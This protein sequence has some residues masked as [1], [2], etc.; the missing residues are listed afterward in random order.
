MH[1]YH[2]ISNLFTR[3][4]ETGDIIEGS[5]TKDEFSHLQNLTWLWTEKFDGTNIRVIFDNDGVAE[6]RGKTDRAQIPPLLLSHLHDKFDEIEEFAG[7]TLYGEGIGYKIQ[8]GGLYVNGE[9]RC[10]FV[11]F[12]VRAGDFWLKR[13]DV[14]GIASAFSI[15]IVPIVSYGTLCQAMDFVRAG[16]KSERNNVLEAEGLICVPQVQLFNRMGERVIVKVKR[17]D[18]K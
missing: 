18:F 13:E 6:Y 5:W 9:Q 8:K 11:L 15:P 1:E 7:L 16:F 12:D 17:R 3:D 10:E 4:R 14:E 2:K